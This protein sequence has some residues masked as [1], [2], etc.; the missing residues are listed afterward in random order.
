M[1][2][3]KCQKAFNFD[4]DANKLKEYYP[5]KNYR[6]A[7]NDIKKFMKKE[8][9]VHR[10]GSGY[11]SKMILNMQDVT[12]L[13]RKIRKTFPWL[14]HCV[15]HFDVTN[16]GERLDLTYMITGDNKMQIQ[17]KK[18]LKT[19]IKNNTEEVSEDNMEN[20][21]KIAFTCNGCSNCK[22]A[23]RRRHDICHLQLSVRT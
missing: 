7:Y 21:S 5:K 13:S 11:I 8:G 20:A 9:F 23:K 18:L 3:E 2:E 16:V 15:Q 12:L 6:Q 19:E 10:Q 22:N 4:L 14:K 17:D 1:K